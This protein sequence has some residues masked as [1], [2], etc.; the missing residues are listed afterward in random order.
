MSANRVVSESGRQNI[1]TI[2]KG[3]NKNRKIKLY[4]FIIPFC[5]ENDIFDD[6]LVRRMRVISLIAEN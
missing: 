4:I 6:S 3:N 1:Y 2:L 5:V